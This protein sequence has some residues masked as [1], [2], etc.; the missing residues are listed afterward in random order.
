MLA[1]RVCLN[2][3]WNYSVAA[4]RGQIQFASRERVLEPADD[5]EKD[6][7]REN[8]DARGRVSFDSLWSEW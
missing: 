6:G 8:G 7:G 5:R 4:G 1:H 3:P 2:R